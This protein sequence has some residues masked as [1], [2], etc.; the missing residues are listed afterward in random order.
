VRAF[1]CSSP[2]TAHLA[3]HPDLHRPIGG[4]GLKEA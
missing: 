1:A 2:P 3:A 4:S